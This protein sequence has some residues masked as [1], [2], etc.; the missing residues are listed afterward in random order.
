MNPQPSFYVRDIPIY[1]DLILAPMAGVSDQPFRALCRR[2]GSAMSYTEFVSCDIIVCRKKPDPQTQRMLIFEPAERPVVFQIFGASEEIIVEAARRIEPLGPDIIDLNMGCPERSI[3]RRGA[4]SGLL[5]DVPKI[6]RIM[7]ALTTALKVP[8]TGK[9]RLGWDGESRNYLEVARA[10]E[11]SGAALIAVHGRTRAQSYTEPADWEP[12]AE[13][14]QAVSIPVVGNGDVTTVADI[15]RMRA[16]TGCD[17]V[18][19]GRGSRGNP[20]L[21]ARR[22]RGQTP[23]AAVLAVIREHLQAMLA[24]YGD[25][26]GL[27]LMRK[28]L[29]WYLQGYS[30]NRALRAALV[31]CEDVGLFL[32][33]L[34]EYEAGIMVTTHALAA[35][36]AS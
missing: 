31:R 15:E 19:I 28:H 3:S 16:Q 21:F 30:G 34:D 35:D 1:G 29:V 22:D 12:I 2:I 6:A 18:M 14:K 17:A 20:W 5:R 10:L 27:I 7:Q 9:I 8:V 24:F 32:R 4:G 26:T 36:R 13:I 23:Q 11:E 25:P 33:L